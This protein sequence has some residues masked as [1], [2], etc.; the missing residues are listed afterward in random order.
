LA[1]LSGK[2]HELTSKEERDKLREVEEEINREVARLF[3]LN[4]EEVGG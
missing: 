4:E 2:A 1:E 3:G